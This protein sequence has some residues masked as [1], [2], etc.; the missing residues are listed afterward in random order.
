M[1]LP[2]FISPMLARS[3]ALFDSDDFLF[4]TK[5]D[6]IRAMLYADQDG[7]RISGRRRRDNTF[8]YPE[9]ARYFGLPAGV[10]LDGEIVVTDGATGDF[11]SVLPREQVRSATRAEALTTT[12]PVNFVA[13]DLLYEA[14]ESRMDDPLVDRRRRLYDVLVTLP[15]DAPV[16]PCPG[17]V[18][19][20]FRFHR[21][22]PPGSEGVMAKRLDSRY[23]PGRRSD[24]W[25]KVK[26]RTSAFCV[27]IGYLL[28]DDKGLKSILVATDQDGALTYVGRVGGGWNE[29]KRADVFERVRTIGR[30]KSVVPCGERAHWIEPVLYCRVSFLDRS[31]NGMLRSPL[32]QDLVEDVT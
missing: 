18:G 31:K 15:E 21:E 14:G 6:G 1:T 16:L 9:L 22:Q 2:D 19:E 23:R 4:E 10:V 32:F 17:L 12:H 20:G 28:D 11:E 26:T 3:G 27:V 8:R 13:F 29:A 7:T 5:W 30:K 24:A 25:Y